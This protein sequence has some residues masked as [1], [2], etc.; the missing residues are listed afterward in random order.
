MAG[1]N[2]PNL[3]NISYNYLPTPTVNNRSLYPVQDGNNATIITSNCAS[4][5]HKSHCNGAT[6]STTS[7]SNF[8]SNDYALQT[9]AYINITLGK[10][11]AIAD[12]GATAHFI[13][14]HVQIINKC[15]AETLLNITLPNAEFIQ[16]TH[17]DN[18]NLPGLGNAATIAHVVPG[19]AHSSLL[20]V[21]QLCDN[22]C[23]V[24]FTKNSCKVFCKAKLMLEGKRHPATGLWIVPTNSEHR[25]VTPEKPTFSS[26]VAHNAYQT[27]SKAKLIQFLHQCA[28]NLSPSTWI[29]AINNEHFLSWPGLTTDAIHKYLPPSTATAKG[30]IKKTLAGVRS[31]HPKQP[32]IKLPAPP[33]MTIPPKAKI[34][35]VPAPLTKDLFPAHKINDV[36]HI[37][38]WATLADQI[39]GTTYTNLTGRFPTMLLKNKQ[40]IFVAYDYTMPSLLEP[41]RT[42][43]HLPLLPLLTMYSPT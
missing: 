21:K 40:F 4:A 14:P 34:K 32:T 8:D 35:H 29:N 12:S 38:C 6:T 1:Y 31:T 30:H 27:T 33:N 16:S 42:A 10:E 11:E 36:N 3:I 39:D 22:G 13:L 28:F 2:N 7:H 19:L 37:F 5:K 15:K 43:K 26:H 18:L 24:I 17:V 20:S 25:N 41:L 23:N 9:T